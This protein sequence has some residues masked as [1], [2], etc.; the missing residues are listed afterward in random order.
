L[1]AQKQD[2]LDRPKGAAQAA[3]F[4][5]I[6]VFWTLMLIATAAVPLALILR[7]V[8]LGGPAPAGH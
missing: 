4:A 8:K 5:Y 6:N 2:R 3:Y 7:N 1:Q